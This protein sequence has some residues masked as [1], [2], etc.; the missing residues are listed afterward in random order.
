LLGALPHFRQLRPTHRS[1]SALSAVRT[2]HQRAADGSAYAAF[3][4]DE[5][6]S[7]HL[8]TDSRST[9]T[10][11]RPRLLRAAKHFGGH[12]TIGSICK[13]N[14]AVA[15]KGESIVAAAKRMRMLHVGTVVV[16]ADRDGKKMPIGI[17]TDR[18]IVLSIVA[19]DAEHL[20]YLSVDEAM[21]DQLLTAGE[22]TS[23]ADALKL[24]QERGVR[25]L[26]V[27]DHAGAL[28]GIVTADD[29][30][31]FLADELGQVVQLM[32]R[33]EQVERRYRV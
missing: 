5:T 19:S 22:E 6:A 4:H 20:P 13:R 2:G 11:R 26:P 21:S 33:E 23:I 10:S 8:V 27:V 3:E 32:N 12:M 15:P 1:K 14:V 9:R 29:V 25:R 30:I 24:M 17:L 28:V 16:V 18:D 7:P 31:R